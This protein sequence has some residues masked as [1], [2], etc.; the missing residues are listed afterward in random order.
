[1][2]YSSLSNLVDLEVTISIVEIK[3]GLDVYKH[4]QKRLM[5]ELSDLKERRFEQK[6][7]LGACEHRLEEYLLEGAM[8][9]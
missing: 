3:M 6:I 5:K 8:K 2:Y 4:I 1:M 7:I 9:E